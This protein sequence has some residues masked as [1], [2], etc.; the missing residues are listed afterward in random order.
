MLINHYLKLMQ[1]KNNLFKLDTLI[2]LEK[3]SS[4]HEEL[5]GMRGDLLQAIS[6]Q[7]DVVKF[8]QNTDDYYFNVERVTSAAQGRVAKAYYTKQGYHHYLIASQVVQH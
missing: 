2:Q 4:T 5:V 6:Y 1:Y 3:D 7:E 8:T